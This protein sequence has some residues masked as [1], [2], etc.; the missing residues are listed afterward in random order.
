MVRSQSMSAWR[1][2]RVRLA[3]DSAPAT[4]ARVRSASWSAQP[5]EH[6]AD[7]LAGGGP[8]LVGQ[9][10]VELDER[11]DEV[12]VGLELG[13]Q[14]RFEQQVGEIEP[15][16]RIALQHLHHRHREVATDVAEPAGHR[17][18]RSAEG[19]GAARTRP[20]TG[21]FGGV[22]AGC[23]GRRRCAGRRVRA[24][25]PPASSAPP[26]TSRQRRMRS[27][28]DTAALTHRRSR[29]RAP[30]GRAAA[31][32]CGVR[33]APARRRAR[34]RP[35]RSAAVAPPARSTPSW[36]RSAGSNAPNVRRSST[37]ASMNTSP[38]MA[39]IQPSIT[40]SSSRSCTSTVPLPARKPFEEARARR[41]AGVP[42]V[43]A[44]HSAPRHVVG[45]PRAAVVQQ[46]GGS[47]AHQPV[48]GVPVGQ[49]GQ[50]RR[51]DRAR[52]A[53]WSSRASAAW[54][55]LNRSTIAAAASSS[56][57][58]AGAVE[59]GDH[60]HHH[61]VDDGRQRRRVRPADVAVAEGMGERHRVRRSARRRRGPVRRARRAIGL[62]RPPPPGRSASRAAATSEAASASRVAAGR[63]LDHRQP[64]PPRRAWCP[65]RRTRP[66]GSA[67]SGSQ[68]RSQ[69]SR[70]VPRAPRPS[71]R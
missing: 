66:G 60:A 59:P 3:R 40:S 70:N 68:S 56:R 52:R 26:S 44:R 13:E 2:R 62:R 58:A 49:H 4:A 64:S 12:H 63:A 36:R 6:A 1:G 53:G 20:A 71:A 18:G 28:S 5:I 46:T 19:A 39:E 22:V 34:R 25:P 43:S 29:N 61:L 23:R 51:A 33:R 42:A 8:G 9:E 17:R 55:P 15:L 21:A 54:S 31:G 47:T 14:L 32:P 65:G 48:H 69:V 35:D 50:Q 57:R 67:R 45:R 30:A 16:D 24:A 41:P 10:A 7:D 11:A 38:G 27:A 37:R